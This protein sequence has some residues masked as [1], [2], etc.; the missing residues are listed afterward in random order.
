MELQ[1]IET[2]IPSSYK[3]ALKM[4]YVNGFMLFMFKTKCLHLS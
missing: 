4:S 2:S 3:E 1:K